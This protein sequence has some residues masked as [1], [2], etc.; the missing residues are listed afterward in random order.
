[1]QRFGGEGS[2]QRLSKGQ[3]P[4]VERLLVVF[5]PA[6]EARNHAFLVGRASRRV[7]SN[8]GQ[9]GAPP[10]SQATD[11]CNQRVEVA[12]TM[13]GRLRMIELHNRP[14]YGTIAAV[15]VTHGISPD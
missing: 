11:Q 10:A 14:F 7:I 5:E 6:S 13:A 9:M 15:R 4:V 3:K 12:F 8:R 2:E 1:M